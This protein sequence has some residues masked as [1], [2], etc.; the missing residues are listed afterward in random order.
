[1]VLLLAALCGDARA[2]RLATVTA[3]GGEIELLTELCN[4]EDTRD[5]ARSGHFGG[6]RL[7]GCWS[8]NAR[9]NPAVMWAMDVC[10]RWPPLVFVLVT[11]GR[12][13]GCMERQDVGDGP[14]ERRRDSFRTP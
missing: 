10:R 7:S 5:P 11:S 4:S 13:P 9:G 1:M 3:A 14:V 2:D 8:V 6:A 12:S